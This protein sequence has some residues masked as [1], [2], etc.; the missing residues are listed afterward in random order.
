MLT[1]WKTSPQPNREKIQLAGAMREDNRTS[2]S[3]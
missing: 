3:A 2:W 1:P